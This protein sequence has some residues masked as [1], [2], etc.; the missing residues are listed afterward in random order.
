[1]N[2]IDQSIFKAYDIRGIYPDQ[3]NPDIAYAIA[4]GYAS[5]LKPQNVVIGHDVRLHSEE[6]KLSMVKGL[7]DAGVNVTDIGLISTEMLYF[8]TGSYGFDGGIQVTASHDS[9]EYHG[10]K[11]VKKD[12]EPISSET[13][14][15]NIKEFV[16]SSKKVSSA[17]KGAIVQ[18]DIL[19]DF[20]RCALGWIDHKNIKSFK[21]VVD[22]NFGYQGTVLDRIIKIGKLPLEIIKLNYDADGNFPKGRPDPQTSENQEEFTK[23]VLEASVDF[24]VTWDADGDRVFFASKEGTFLDAYYTDTLLI[25][26]MLEKYPKQKIVYDPRSIGATVN[27]IKENGGVPILERVGHSFIKARMRSED[28][29]FS[30]EF[31]GHTYY[32]DF[33]YADSGIIPFLQILEILSKSD[34]TLEQLIKPVMNKYFISGEINFLTDRTKEIMEAIEEKYSDSLVDR[35]DG[36]SCQYPDWRFN[37]RTSNTGLQLLRLNVESENKQ[38]L[39]QKLVELKEIIEPK[40]K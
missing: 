1:M 13:G 14:L 38:L 25:Q 6:L 18:K 12:A 33:W 8:A 22:P 23:K 4:Q 24:G 37:I 30:G 11:F 10:A 21:I 5:F 26:Y 40:I 34:L 3:I 29:I 2:K 15:C 36:I 27:A 16:L 35:T 19:D 39:G 32:K 7:V 28:A 9:A 20:C 31:S 17:Q